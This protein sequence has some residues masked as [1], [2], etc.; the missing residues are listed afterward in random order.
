MFPVIAILPVDL[1]A[2]HLVS[3]SRLNGVI[4]ESYQVILPGALNG[5]LRLRL[6]R[7]SRGRTNLSLLGIA[8]LRVSLLRVALLRIALLRVALPVLVILLRS[9]RRPVCVVP[10]RINA[11]SVGVV[12]VIRIAVTVSIVRVPAKA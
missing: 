10:V 4:G 2:F 12:S 3:V 11:V 9:R 6:L 7:C 1:I 5:C 8:L